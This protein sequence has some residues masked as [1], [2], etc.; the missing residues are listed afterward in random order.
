MI[1]IIGSSNHEEFKKGE[2]IFKFGD[3]GDKF[4]L[5]LHGKV[6]INLPRKAYKDMKRQLSN[7]KTTG[8]YTLTALRD[9]VGPEEL[10][11]RKRGDYLAELL[12]NVQS[13]QD[14]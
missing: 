5:I 2:K 13:I 9:S 1:E 14:L 11:A 10:E 6:S 3:V 12:E 8:N 4:Y 7:I